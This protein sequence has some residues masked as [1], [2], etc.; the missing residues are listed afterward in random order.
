MPKINLVYTAVADGSLAPRVAFANVTEGERIA[1]SSSFELVFDRAMDKASVEAA[2]V[3]QP[4]IAGALSW[5][6]ARTVA[7]TPNTPLQRGLTVDLGIAQA[8][9]DAT[10]T[11]LREPFQVRVVAQGNLEILQTLPARDADAVQPDTLV[12]VMFNR[13]V[14]ALGLGA[15]TVNAGQSP[16]TFDPPLEG[17]FEWLNT[18]VLVFNPS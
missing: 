16:L 4:K 3:T 6:D 12:T 8:A 9:K 5:K 7:F 2:F 13:P 11:Q 10:G 14:I 15:S 18:S 1:P 17:K